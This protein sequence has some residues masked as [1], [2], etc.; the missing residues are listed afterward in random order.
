MSKNKKKTEA[1][2][3]FAAWEELFVCPLC[4]SPMHVVQESSLVCSN[5]HCFDLAR[6]GYVNLLTH[7]VKAAYAR[8]M[9][10]SRKLI[11]KSGF[12]DPL[13]SKLSEAILSRQTHTREPIRILDAGCGEGSHLAHI[14]HMIGDRTSSDVIG[15]GI[16]VSKDAI[17]LATS[18]TSR[19]L[20]CVADLANCP[21]AD[22]QYT[23][24]LNILSPANYAQFQRLLSEDGIVLKV[25]P[26]Q[27]YLRELRE[28]LYV[29]DERQTYTNEETT[30]L[31]RRQFA[32][33]ETI[34]VQYTAQIEP[35]NLPHLLQMTP[36][37]W[38][39]TEE[40]RER[41]LQTGLS[42]VSVD[43]SILVGRNEQA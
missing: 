5:Q 32:L 38:G 27:D 28:S 37:S 31:F 24:I 3:L 18:E 23:A 36:L 13:L 6:Q 19:S 33:L 41:L 26:E 25:V 7:P 35:G 2:Q 4:A 30:A 22:K 42:A 17:A 15:V 12:F 21:F 1:A 39:A 34:R 43:F 16:D 14:Q 40:Q 20:W 11:S 8:E 10:A 29:L 9:F